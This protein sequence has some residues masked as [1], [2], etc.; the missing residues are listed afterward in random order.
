MPK[1]DF[2]NKKDTDFAAQL[3]QFKSAVGPYGGV[4]G[5]SATQTQQQAGDADYFAYAVTCQ[6]MMQN[7]AQQWTAWRDLMRGGG[8]ITG[9]PPQTPN[10]P[11]GPAVLPDPGI[12][13]RFRALVKFIKSSAGYSVAIGQALGIEGAQQTAPDL[14]AIQPVLTATRMGSAVNVG[15]GWQGNSAFL[16]MLEIQADR[17][18]GHGWVFLTYDT[19]PNYTDT[20]PFPAAPVKWKYRAIYR[21][22]DAQVG[23][24]SNTVEITVGG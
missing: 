20:A 5:V 3:E 4:L 6:Q 18:D 2:V 21:V 14:A 22:G 17:G 23:L 7:A 1:S 11:P 16:D 12:E 24:W 8:P 9:N 19:T 10:L 13:A 15:W